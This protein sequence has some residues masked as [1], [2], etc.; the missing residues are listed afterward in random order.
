MRVVNKI[1]NKRTLCKL[2]LH[3]Y[4]YVSY[5][6]ALTYHSYLNP[7]IHKRYICINCEKEKIISIESYQPV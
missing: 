3:K 2:N 4:I 1:I 6:K 5:K 7:V